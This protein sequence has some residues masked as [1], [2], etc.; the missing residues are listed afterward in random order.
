MK[1]LLSLNKYLYKYRGRLFLGTLFIIGLNFFMVYKIRYVGKAVNFIKASLNSGEAGKISELW[2][3]GAL[4]IVLPLVAV[5]LQFL[6]RQTIIVA[7]RHME[8]DL[9]NVIYEHYQELDTSFYKN[10]R[11]GDLMNR[12][13]EDVS[14]VRMY[15]G[16]GIM[17]PIN[18]L[19]MSVILIIEMLSIDKT[20]TLFTLLPLPFLSV[21]VY[22]LSSK[23]NRKSRELQAEQSNLS[24]FVQDMFSG[25]RVIKSFGK[26]KSVKRNYAKNVKKYKHKAIELA[27]IDAFFSPL[28]VVIIGVSQIVILY[29]G[30]MRYINGQIQEIGTLAQFFMYLNMLIWPFTSLGWVS[31]VVQRASSS[32]KRINEFLNTEPSVQN[33]GTIKAKIQG[34]INF[35]K[36]DFVYDNT[37]IQALKNVSFEVPAGETLA[38]LGKTGSGKTT[39]AE[40]ISRLCDPTRGVVKIDDQDLKSYDLFSLRN[41]IGVVPQEAFLFST[42]LRENL[43]FGADKDTLELAQKYAEKADL[44]ENITGFREGYDTVVGE[45][46]VTLSGGQKQRLSIA[47]ALIKKPKILIFD[48]S[49]SAVDTETETTILNNIKQESE[50]K[51]TIIITHRVSSAKHA[52]QIIVLDCGEIIERGT[53]Q[54]LMDL[55]GVYCEMYT[56]QTQMQD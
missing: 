20:M 51:T 1:E 53:H 28:I 2:Y 30:G 52:Q 7:S 48:D 54:D 27:N 4:I 18:L 50:G 9:K 21:L 55:G 33:T 10:N 42:S 46:G 47:R 56:Q 5:F 12:I 36:V 3:Y 43:N 31:M 41:Q 24:A 32:M 44:H 49:L 23:I 29:V 13:S 14:Y 45:R 26:E 16:P 11:I 6:M 40:L 35:E 17:Y 38:I 37:G 22:F 25:I 8:Y 19:A 39:I 34:K 15:L